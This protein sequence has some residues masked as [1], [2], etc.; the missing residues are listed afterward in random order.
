MVVNPQDVGNLGAILRK[1]LA[2]F[3]VFYRVYKTVLAE[4]GEVA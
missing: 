4:T 2:D 3:A 1:G